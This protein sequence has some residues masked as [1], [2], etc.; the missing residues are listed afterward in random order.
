MTEVF[1]I[2]V[3]CEDRAEIEEEAQAPCHCADEQDGGLEVNRVRDETGEDGRECRA[4]VL[5]EVFGGLRRRADFGN[6]DVIHGCDDVGGG[7]RH[8]DGG[9]AHKD[10]ELVSRFNGRI[11]RE[12]NE[13]R[14]HQ[15]TDAGND[16]AS[17]VCTFEGCVPKRAA[18]EISAGEDEDDGRHR[19]E[20]AVRIISA[21]AFEIG[22]E[23]IRDDVPREDARKALQKDEPHGFLFEDLLRLLP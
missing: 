21:F 13:D 12:V 2:L 18:D 23:E 11:E 4:R 10:E 5:D 14:A 16:D 9:Q 15:N 22:E 8:E 1:R 7:K 3:D 6:R 19:E 20:D 17:F